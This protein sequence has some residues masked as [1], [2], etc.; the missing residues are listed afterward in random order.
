VCFGTSISFL[1]Y[2]L[3]GS[4]TA[5]VVGLIASALDSHG[6]NLQQQPVETKT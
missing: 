5:I 4:V 1:W 3:S 6:P 2:S